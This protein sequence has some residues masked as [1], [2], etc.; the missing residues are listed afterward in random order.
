MR[1]R[2]TAILSFFARDTILMAV[3]MMLLGSL[4]FGVG[5][6]AAVALAG[7]HLAV[8][9]SI[10]AGGSASFILTVVIRSH[11]CIRVFIG[12]LSEIEPADLKRHA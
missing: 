10:G 4:I 5:V 9:I 8:A 11:R 6:A 7:I 3:A 2:L 1:R 12:A